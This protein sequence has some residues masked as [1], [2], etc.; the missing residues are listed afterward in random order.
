MRLADYIVQVV[1][2]GFLVFGLFFLPG[3][4]FGDD[5]PGT[6]QIS[7]LEVVNPLFWWSLPGKIIGYLLSPIIAGIGFVMFLWSVLMAVRVFRAAFG[8]R[9]N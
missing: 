3:V 6:L 5:K 2:I 4:A 1:F 7:I 8:S 9:G